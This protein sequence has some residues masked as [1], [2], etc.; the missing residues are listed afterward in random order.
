ML[1]GRALLIDQTREFTDKL[2]DLSGE[3]PLTIAINWKLAAVSLR[4]SSSLISLV[5]V[6]TSISHANGLDV[7]KQ[8]RALR[9]TLPIIMVDH[10]D[11]PR[12][13]QSDLDALRCLAL[14]H[15]P[16][17]AGDLWKPLLERLDAQNAWDKISATAEPIEVPLD[18]DGK[19][20]IPTPIKDFLITPK[21][22]FNLY[23][24][25]KG[26]KYVKV[27]NAGD[28]VEPG[29]AGKYLQKGATHFYIRTE[30]HQSYI[31]LCDKTMAIMLGRQSVGADVKVQKLIH[32]GENIVKS[33]TQY[34]ITVE[35][36][37]FADNFL[38]H[39][40]TFARAMRSDGSPLDRLLNG[41]IGKDHVASVAM[42]AGLLAQQMGLESDKAV[43]MVGMAA[44]FHDVGLYD[45]L[46]QLEHEDPKDL[47]AEDRAKWERHPEHG[48]QLL[49]AVGGF[50][51]V[52]Y[53]AIAQHHKRKRGD[54]NRKEASHINM[55][56]E[57]IGVVDEFHNTVLAHDAK[58]DA[59]LRFER[60]TLPL[61]SPKLAEAF[62]TMLNKGK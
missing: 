24:H 42:L 32:L 9:P 17:C 25:L 58:P 33:F 56:S 29:F 48:E 60:D 14:V 11:F 8:V 27:L 53:Q 41:L 31:N 50:E 43:K 4:S 45:L 6:S 1:H 21:A 19:K 7:V 55:V 54:L 3:F 39:T 51:E 13:S 37:H 59:M 2:R 30:E 12:V 49:R 23:I 26:E 44:L 61:F 16:T 18:I 35:K 52:V 46:P 28:V 20:F 62:L 38:E 40:V 10:F 36:I 15:K 34:G 47:S 22:Y 57:I 5:F